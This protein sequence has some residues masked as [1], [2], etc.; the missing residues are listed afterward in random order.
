MNHP[1][2]PVL[3]ES[4]L[5]HAQVQAGDVWID[6]TLGRG[7]HSED[8]LRA[9]A[10][11]IAFDKD[12]QALDYSRQRLSHFNTFTSIASDFRYIKEQLTLQG[13]DKVQGILADLGVSSP[14]L[15]QAERGFSWMQSG[16]VDMRMNPDAGESA[17]E[18]IERLEVPQL[19]HIIKRYGEEP[20]AF[21]IAKKIKLWSQQGGGDTRSLADCIAQALPARRRK[22]LK[23]NPATLTFQALRIAVNDELGALEDLLE[24]APH[25]LSPEG[26]LLL[27]SFHSL[28]D[29]MVK[30]RFRQLSEM[31]QP[32]RRG[33]P[34]PLDT[35]LPQ[36][37]QIPRKPI[38]PSSQEL[39]ENRRARSAKLRVLVHKPLHK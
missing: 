22:K 12:S 23:K 10:R 29:R 5:H 3:R 37:V 18:L 31:P 1:H 11:V 36:F 20:A 24:D 17:L 35:P 25:L 38:I 2:I 8:L 39:Q 21:M 33:L 19:A 6:C 30:H 32:P 16:P 34:L 14:Q 9:G 27:I 15:D 4:I 13:I 7:G 26:R 28:E